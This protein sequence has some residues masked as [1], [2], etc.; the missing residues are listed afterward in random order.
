MIGSQGLAPGIKTPARTSMAGGGASGVQTRKDGSISFGTGK[1]LASQ[2]VTSQATL[3]P[4][5]PLKTRAEALRGSRVD[6]SA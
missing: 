2:I 6:I 5:T 3:D 4:V 1:R